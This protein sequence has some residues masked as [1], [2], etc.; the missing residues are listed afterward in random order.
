MIVHDYLSNVVVIFPADNHC[1]EAGKTL[2]MF[3]GIKNR[4]CPNS[5]LKLLACSFSL[6]INTSSPWKQLMTPLAGSILTKGVKVDI[7]DNATPYSHWNEFR[8]LF[9][10][11]YKDPA[12]VIMKDFHQIYPELM[13]AI[14]FPKF[15]KD[16][17]EVSSSILD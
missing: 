15:S 12:Q 5:T 16:F 1:L 6:S 14:N 8:A 2:L 7:M 10:D 3:G 17:F 4:G 9:A 13:E 11:M